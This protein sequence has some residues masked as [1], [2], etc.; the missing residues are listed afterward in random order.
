M[1]KISVTDFKAEVDQ[2]ETEATRHATELA[3]IKYQAEYQH[4]AAEA[5]NAAR[6]LAAAQTVHEFKATDLHDHGILVGSLVQDNERAQAKFRA[7]S[8]KHK[9]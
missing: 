8:R 6:S 5:K 2:A 4:L 9:V 3:N 1:A 7:S